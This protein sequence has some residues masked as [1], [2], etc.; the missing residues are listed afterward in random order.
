MRLCD[1]SPQNISSH[2]SFSLHPDPNPNPYFAKEVTCLKIK[3]R[4]MNCREMNCP[5]PWI[6][7]RENDTYKPLQIK[8]Y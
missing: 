7:G 8:Y 4:E 2:K 5:V 3:R 1:F 6:T